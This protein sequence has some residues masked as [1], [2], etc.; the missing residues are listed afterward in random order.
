MVLEPVVAVEAAV[1]VVMV[2]GFDSKLVDKD[3][4]MEVEVMLQVEET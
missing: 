1:A 4:K 3:I 2:L